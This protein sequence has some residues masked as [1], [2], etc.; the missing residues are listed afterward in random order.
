MFGQT[1]VAQTSTGQTNV[2]GQNNASA[3]VFG[4]TTSNFGAN[5]VVGANGTA[6]A[7]Y[8]PVI[9]T[10]TL[11]KNG[12]TNTVNTKLHCIT[13]MKEY[14]SKSLE[15]LRIE[16]YMA[17]RK[18]PQSVGNGIFGATMNSGPF[19]AGGFSTASSTA[20]FGQQ[21]EN[22]GIFGNPGFGQTQTF[23]ATNQTPA[24]GSLFGKPFPAPAATAQPGLGGFANANNAQSN[25]FTQK[26][27]GAQP[28]TTGL[29][30]QTPAT[31]APSFGQ[32]TSSFATF[33]QNNSIQQ[34]PLFGQ[35][36]PAFALTSTANTSFGGF[37]TNANTNTAGTT[38]FGAKPQT[39]GFGTAPGIILY[40][41]M[42]LCLFTYLY[43]FT[44][45]GTASAAT[46][47]FGG[48]GQTNTGGSLFNTSF[49]KPATTFGGF[50]GQTTT[51]PIGN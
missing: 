36:K 47:G 7:K 35:D 31:A 50:G 40:K 51:A 6:I 5:N 16:D 39:T 44:A 26:P 20:G 25:I 11:I 21:T 18:G 42:F 33:G 13:S 3:N 19:G 29:F 46:G 45:F 30:G 22:K 49:N 38:L 17:N 2:F 24:T 9:G 41:I 43:L 37:G 23:G 8:Q 4:N 32:N 15:E 14:E 34:A 28:T 48:F 1:N 27:F 10:D 12:Q